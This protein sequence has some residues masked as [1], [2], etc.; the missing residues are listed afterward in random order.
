[1]ASRLWAHPP[2]P[3]DRTLR[4][5]W[6]GKGEDRRCPARRAIEALLPGDGYVLASRRSPADAAGMVARCSVRGKR[7]TTRVLP[8]GRIMV[9]RVK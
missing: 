6:S 4:P 3:K 1:M 7:F 2:I 8:C 9:V 5:F